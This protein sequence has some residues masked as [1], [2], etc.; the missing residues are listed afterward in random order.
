MGS[1]KDH[2]D[3]EDDDDDDRNGEDSGEDDGDNLDTGGWVLGAPGTTSTL[4]M[5]ATV[6]G[7]VRTMVRMVGMIWTLA[8]AFILY[9]VRL[10]FWCEPCGSYP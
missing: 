1:S 5:M 3:I 2:I 4:R 10:T 7:T 8:M 9:K 6:T